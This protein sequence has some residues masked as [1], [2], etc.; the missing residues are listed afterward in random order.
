[1]WDSSANGASRPYPYVRAATLNPSTLAVLSQPDIFGTANAWIY[2]A[3]SVN[4]RR[5]LGGT[6]DFLGGNQFPTIGAIIRDDFSPHPATSGW[7]AYS[8]A[9]GNSGTLDGTATTTE[10]CRTR[11]TR[12]PGW[13][14]GIDRS[15]TAPTSTPPSESL[16][17]ATPPAFPPRGDYEG[18][19]DVDFSQLRGAAWNFYNP[20][21]LKG[22]FVGAAGA[23]P[24]PADY[25][26]AVQRRGSWHFCDFAAGAH[27]PGS[28]VFVGGSGTPVPMDYDGDGTAGF[29]QYASGAWHFYSDNGSYNRG[30]WLG[31]TPEDVPVPF[32]R[33]FDPTE[34]VVLFNNGIY[35]CF[36][37]ATLTYQGG[38]A[39][40][41]LSQP[42]PAPLDLEGDG[43][44]GLEVFD[45]DVWHFYA[46]TGAY[47]GGACTGNA[48]DKPI[49]R[50]LLP[51]GRSSR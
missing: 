38:V 42:V 16:R 39:L 7:E 4:E 6:F 12:R 36:D 50:R 30:F 2:P 46:R 10:R 43:I 27:L 11:N 45:S 25:N 33:D 8:I 3:M 24:V 13:P 26:G 40:G 19:G 31:N 9:D 20:D 51:K 49:S 32:S 47:L 22:I 23:K 44:L 17:E 35:Y 41:T 48:G 18:D 1:M 29:T 21:G 28:S 5:H 15:A 14:S 34:E 37:L